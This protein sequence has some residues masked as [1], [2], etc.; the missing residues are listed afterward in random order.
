M[1]DARVIQVL[2][3]IGVLRLMRQRILAT[4][5]VALVVS[6]AG[7]SRF[8][9][10]GNTMGLDGQAELGSDARSPKIRPETGLIR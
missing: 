7:L 10:A 6:S 8:A 1:R 4:L 2:G 9:A 5:F 3:S